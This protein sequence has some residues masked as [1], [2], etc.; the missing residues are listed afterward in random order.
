MMSKNKNLPECLSQSIFMLRM[1]ATTPNLHPYGP[2]GPHA[3]EGA[4]PLVRAAPFKEWRGWPSFAR[5]YGVRSAGM[6]FFS[7]YGQRVQSEKQYANMVS[8]FFWQ[9]RRG[10]EPVIYGDEGRP[11]TSPMSMMWWRLCACPRFGWKKVFSA[12][13]L[14]LPPRFSAT[15]YSKIFLCFSIEFDFPRTRL[16]GKN[17]FRRGPY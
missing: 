17:G 7:V 8:Q 4:R 9:M 2:R 11:A 16:S 5:L 3:R 1:P 15:P 6:R 12:T 14:Y 13:Y 10:E